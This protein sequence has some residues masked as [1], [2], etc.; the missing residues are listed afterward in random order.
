MRNSFV[1]A[2]GIAGIM[3]FVNVGAALPQNQASLPNSFPFTDPSVIVQTFTTK[4]AVV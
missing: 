1:K 2:S 4:G 3:L